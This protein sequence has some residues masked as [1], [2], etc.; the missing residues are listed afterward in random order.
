MR[1]LLWHG[2]LLSGS[3]SNLYS[4]NVAREWRALGH[5]VLLLCQERRAGDLPFVD[6]QGDFESDNRVFSVTSTGVREAAGRCRVVRPAIGD[7]LPVYVY[8]EYE[9]FT[10][11]RFVD[12]T[13]EELDR[14]TRTNVD[15]LIT[16]IED[17][18]PDAIITGHEVM[19]PYIAAGACERTGTTFA[20]KLHGSALEYAVKEQ[21]RYREFAHKGLSRAR[22]VIGGSEYM[23]REAASVVPGWA[24]R[25]VVVNP[26][27]DVELFRP[28]AR[29]PGAPPTVGYVGK[30]IVSKGV[31]HFLAAL[32]LT[33]IQDLRA[34]VIGYG[35]FEP[36]LRRMAAALASGDFDA[37]AS[38]ARTGERALM[39]RL[40]AFIDAVDELRYARR[41]SQIEIDFAGR[42]DHE[43]LSRVLPTFDVLVVPSVVPEAFG[44]VAAEAAACGVLPLVPRHSGIGEVGRALEDAIDSPGT[45]TY[46]PEDPIAGIAEG[47]DSILA[48]DPVRR[49]EMEG[50]ATSF[51]RRKWSWRTIADDLLRHATA[52][53][54]D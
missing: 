25:A 5:D 22:V 35:G 44:M 52:R 14:Y 6:A 46:D 17:H 18:R 47:I 16:A 7:I 45:L 28:I 15:A 36:E 2:Y 49:E 54:S 26:G 34:V 4:A 37:V 8:D 38:V 30:L 50:A 32:G 42:L 53:Y 1:V 13:D 33:T 19:G 27:C 43:P 21:A 10:A 24:E 3:G 23:V 48:L 20:A 11:K 39:D 29:R 31:H 9:G 40:L 51:A 12:L 41:A